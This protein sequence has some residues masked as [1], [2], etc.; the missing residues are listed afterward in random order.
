MKKVLVI[1][2]FLMTTVSLALMKPGQRL[3]PPSATLS[4][5]TKFIAWSNKNKATR[6]MINNPVEFMHAMR[7]EKQ[8]IIDALFA[9]MMCDIYL[10]DASRER[11]I[12]N[13][14]LVGYQLKG[15]DPVIV[16]AYEGNTLAYEQTNTQDREIVTNDCAACKQYK[17]KLAHYIQVLEYDFMHRKIK[18]DEQKRMHNLANASR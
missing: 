4:A 18:K 1:S 7:R 12:F 17:K 14:L 15:R 3:K 13:E 11:T 9:Y 6:D 10:S 2:I 5:I 16:N 8:L